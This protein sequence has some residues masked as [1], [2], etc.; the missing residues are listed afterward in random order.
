MLIRQSYRIRIG[1]FC[2]RGLLVSLGFDPASYILRAIRRA[3]GKIGA[4]H[5]VFVRG[6]GGGL[7]ALRL[8][9][10][11]PGSLAYVH[12]GTT[13]IALSIRRSVHRYFNTVWEGWDQHQRLEAFPERF[14][15][16]RR[17]R[18]SQ[19]QNFVY[20]AQSE[21]DTRF[22]YDHY[23]PFKE[24][25]SISKDSRQNETWTRKFVL[26]DGEIKGRG[27]VTHEKF[28]YHFNNAI[29]H[30]RQLR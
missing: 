25:H 11:W 18:A 30:W 13:N 22:R 10:M 8:S 5:V 26:Y 6:S 14:D 4:K 12:E 21:G 24:A 27:N 15:M 7:V 2:W 19:P 28:N 16:V 3:L 23:L 29:N 17:Y 20:H 1:R 9:A